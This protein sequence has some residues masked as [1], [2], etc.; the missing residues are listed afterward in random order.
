[1][2]DKTLLERLKIAAGCYFG[3][4]SPLLREAALR[5][6]E[7]YKET[8]E[9]AEKNI[10][11]AEEVG[12]INIKYMEALN[13]LKAANINYNTAVVENIRL[14]KVV[15]ETTHANDGL[16]KRN[17]ELE[18]NNNR[19]TVELNNLALASHS[20]KDGVTRNDE[21]RDQFACVAL[22]AVMINFPFNG[23][24][25]IAEQAYEYADAMLKVRERK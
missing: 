7:Q 17:I 18:W 13:Q 20:D 24:K 19:L 21:L 10:R 11:L 14:N 12:P 2:N 4:I 5:I 22:N 8:R 23:C 1:M 3:E 25:G 15:N 16:I 9:L 6:E